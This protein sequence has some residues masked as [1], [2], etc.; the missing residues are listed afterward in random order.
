M[1]GI[2]RA[3]DELGAFQYNCVITCC[4]Q[5]LESYCR[6]LPVQCFPRTSV[7]FGRYRR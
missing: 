2:D 3:V 5:K 1:T 7:E 6:R 4:E